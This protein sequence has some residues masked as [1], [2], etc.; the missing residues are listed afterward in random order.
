MEVKH[1]LWRL[2]R[3]V[4]NKHWLFNMEVESMGAQAVSEA[5][6]LC[7]WAKEQN[8]ARNQI[9]RSS[10]ATVLY[11]NSAIEEEVV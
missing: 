10:K 4:I 5:K 2:D 7:G 11:D 3:S 9:S 8:R 1:S 6:I